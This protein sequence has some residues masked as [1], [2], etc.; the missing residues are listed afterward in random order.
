LNSYLRCLV[1]STIRACTN[2]HFLAHPIL[3]VWGSTIR[4]A[5]GKGMLSE[6]DAMHAAASNDRYFPRVLRDICLRDGPDA[7]RENIRS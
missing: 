6:K 3:L 4:F 2:L 7:G 1:V 5:R